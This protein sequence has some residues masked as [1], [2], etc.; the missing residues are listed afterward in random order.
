MQQRG[1][2]AIIL[3]KAQHAGHVQRHSRPPRRR[4]TRTVAHGP[5]PALHTQLRHCVGNAPQREQSLGSVQA[6]MDTGM[7]FGEDRS[8]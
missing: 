8:T 5:V 7:S 3:A 4:A 2:L 6:C 1:R